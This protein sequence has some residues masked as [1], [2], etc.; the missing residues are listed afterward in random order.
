[1]TTT[2]A[3]IALTIAGSDSGGGAGIQADLKTFAAL[4]AYGCSALTALT[5]QNTLGVQAIH[6]VPPAFVAAQLDS[7]LDDL[8][9]AAIKIGMLATA[10][11]A[12][13]VADALARRVGDGGEGP[14]IVLDPVMVATSGD[15]LIDDDA[16]AVVAER[17]L[18]LATVVT[19][20][21]PEAGRLAALLG[22]APEDAAGLAAR[23]LE[24]GAR[25]VL[26][27]GGHREGPEVR[28]EL[29]RVG[30]QPLVIEHPRLQT[31]HSHGTGCTLSS[32]LA[33]RLAA[34][35]DLEQA[36]REALDYLHEAL[37]AAYPVGGGRG[38]VHHMV[39]LWGS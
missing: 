30:A 5:A 3:P 11:V 17:L 18:P 35:L 7:V 9:V 2:H 24:L 8:P 28:D 10:E 26:L 39:R 33:A 27:K 19:P 13:A 1:M 34:G 32:A 22:P 21:W 31:P 37:A 25:A 36:T 38:P 23:V 20:N 15:P 12:A 14:P 16:V 4:G 6:A 29:W